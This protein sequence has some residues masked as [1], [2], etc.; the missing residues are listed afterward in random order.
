VGIELAM[1]ITG[2]AKPTLYSLISARKIPI[3]PATKTGSHII[4]HFLV[5]QFTNEEGFTERDKEI[6]FV[7]STRTPDV[8]TKSEKRFTSSVRA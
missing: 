6:A 1:Q 4:P 3:R 2:L 5:K 8:A 7:L